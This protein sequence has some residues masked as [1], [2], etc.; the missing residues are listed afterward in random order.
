VTWTPWGATPPT[1]DRPARLKPV[2]ATIRYCPR[3]DATTEWTNEL[4]GTTR[5]SC[6]G[7][8]LIPGGALDP[9]EHDRMV[10]Y[11]EKPVMPRRRRYLVT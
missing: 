4:S 7:C 9:D 2:L 6:T 1:V 3:C 5:L 8:G 11:D 10:A